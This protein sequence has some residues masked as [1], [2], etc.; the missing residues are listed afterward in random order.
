MKIKHVEELVG[1][2][3]KNIRYYEEEGLLA[4]GRAE[5]G[6]REYHEDDIRRL[7]QIRLLRRLT[8]PIG[9]IRDVFEGKQDLTACLGRHLGELEKQKESLTAMQEVSRDLMEK[10][11]DLS[12]VDVDLCLEQMDRLE[13]EGVKFMDVRLEDVHRKKMAGA[14]IGALIMFGIM[15]LI[16]LF[17]AWGQSRA[18]LPVGMFLLILAVPL[19]VMVC[20][21]AVLIQRFKEIKGGEEDEASKY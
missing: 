21:I 3:R 2:T 4:P 17:V 19:I 20:I 6:Y 1:I 5:N 11:A 7:K 8:V 12:S 10:H 14:L 15:G 18:P 16:V 9:E 13:K